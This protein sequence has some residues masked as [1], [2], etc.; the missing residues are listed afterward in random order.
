M[1]VQKEITPR[2]LCGNGITNVKD[3][4]LKYVIYSF[5]HSGLNTH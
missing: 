1:V 3:I 2:Y 4:V 5:T